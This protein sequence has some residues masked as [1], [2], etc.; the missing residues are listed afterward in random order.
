MSSA[1]GKEK[2]FLSKIVFN[3]GSSPLTKEKLA[4][5]VIAMPPNKLA[6]RTDDPEE[7]L[8]VARKVL[9]ISAEPDSEPE[10]ASDPVLSPPWEDSPIPSPHED[11]GDEADSEA[12]SLDQLEGM[13]KS[14]LQDKAEDLGLDSSG[15]KAEIFDRIVEFLDL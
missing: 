5:A 9:G 15:L 11:D 6:S 13:N 14:E 12:L 3:T 7:A 8:A 1:R 10:P 4:Q 2:L